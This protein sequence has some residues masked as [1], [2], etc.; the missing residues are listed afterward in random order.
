M[1]QREKSP[2]KTI[3]PDYKDELINH[4]LSGK[5]K[6]MRAFA[7]MQKEK[8]IWAPYCQKKDENENKKEDQ[9][10]VVNDSIEDRKTD[11]SKEVTKKE[12]Y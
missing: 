4:S 2:S 9:D 1:N 12:S 6:I 7:E 11:L 8:S 10:L 5:Y 3:D